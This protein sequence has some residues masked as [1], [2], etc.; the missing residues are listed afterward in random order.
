MTLQERAAKLK[1]QEI[2]EI[3]SL[4]TS[5]DDLVVTREKLTEENERLNQQLAWFKRQV[6]GPRSERR[7]LDAEGRQMALGEVLAGE[8]REV[9]PTETVREHARRRRKQPWEGTPEDSGLRFDPAVVPVEVIEVPNPELEGLSEEGYEVVREKVTYRLAQRPGS[10]VVLEY[11]RQVVK[12]REKGRLVSPSA[13]PA[14]LEKSVAD[15]S[16]LAGMLIDKFCYYLPLYRQ[17]Q[18]LE[19]NGIQLSRATLTNLVH[20]VAELLEPIYQALLRSVLEGQLVSMD[21][22]PIKA[23]RPPEGGKMRTGYF[24]PVYGDRDEVVFPFSPSRGA[25]MV[26]ET[27]GE[28]RGVLLTDG[29]EPYET[30]TAVSEGRVVHAQCLAHAR[31]KFV[32]AESSEPALCGEALGYIREIYEQEA[33]I[34]KLGL[35]GE[36]KLAYRQERIKPI[37]DA[38]FEWL[39]ESLEQHL[40]LPSNPFT[41]AAAYAQEREDALKVFLNYPYVPIDTN[42]LERQIRPIA[43]G[44]KNWMFCWTEV[45]ARYV[46]IVQSLLATCRLHGVDAY[47]YLVDVLQRIDTHPANRVDELIPRLWKERFAHNPRRS[48]IDRPRGP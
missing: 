12:V 39:Q 14:V 13:P 36:H 4:L 31:R 21:E 23:D 6:F 43:L 16:F 3:A 2:G 15:V 40:L 5:Y 41:V 20:R 24:W 9:E 17:H 29:Y 44:R 42:H 18:R 28:F 10:Y 32:E 1:D 7:I 38:F 27:L 26:W 22:T 48:A 37:V 19:A 47:T 33:T 45:G 46:G 25:R 8:S 35:E 30:Y 11:R 34:R